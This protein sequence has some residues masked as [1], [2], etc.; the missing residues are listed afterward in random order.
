[1]RTSISHIP[2]EI[3]ALRNKS[4]QKKTDTIHNAINQE[5]VSANE[6]VRLM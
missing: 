3:M 1:M 6:N 5:Y 2:P 4:I